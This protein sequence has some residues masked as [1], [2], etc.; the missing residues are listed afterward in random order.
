[1][2]FTPM[3][4]GLQVNGSLVMILYGPQPFKSAS[5]LQFLNDLAA[6]IRSQPFIVSEETTSIDRLS[7][8]GYP[9]DLLPF[10]NTYNNMYM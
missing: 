2:V 10:N 5:K 6:I 9:V 1:M 8:D 3:L 7:R 4:S